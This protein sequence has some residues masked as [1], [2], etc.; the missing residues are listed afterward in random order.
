MSVRVRVAELSDHPAISRI[1][2][3][4]YE[5][6]GQL[7]DEIPYAATLADVASRAAAGEVYV[8]VDADDEVL[9]AVTFVLPG[10]QFAELSGPGEAEFRMLAVDP[11]AQGRGVG[12]A[13]ARACVS[14]ARELGCSAVVICARDFAAPAQRL[15]ARL[16]FVREPE[17]DW[18]P[19]P[20]V[21]LLGLR[22]TL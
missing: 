8:A 9:G 4:A 22:L 19:M 15:Y 1:S 18:S 11:V 20:G 5:A 21:R 2:V 3:A 17:L 14:R 6:D 16:G 7:K 12:D 13:L 10:S